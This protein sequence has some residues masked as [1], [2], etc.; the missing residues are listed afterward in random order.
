MAAKATAALFAKDVRDTVCSDVTAQDAKSGEHVQ[1]M[2][3]VMN[4]RAG[5]KVAAPTAAL[6]RKPLNCGN[7]HFAQELE[8]NDYP[9]QARWKVLQ[10]MSF[11]RRFR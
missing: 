8:I 2:A 4:M 10:A 6:T 5:V 1:K 9:Q 3:A 7:G 11:L